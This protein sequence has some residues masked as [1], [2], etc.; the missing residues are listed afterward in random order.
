MRKIIAVLSLVIFA[1]PSMAGALTIDPDFGN[2]LD[3]GTADLSST[4]INVIQWAL[5]LLGLVAVAVIIFGI[6]VV[7]TAGG[8]DRADRA[9][10]LI[11]GAVI[12]LFIII[13]AWSI[14]T[15]VVNTGNE[16]TN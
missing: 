11:I 14:V 4:V 1:L 15:F 13:I 9:K 10:R 12:G 5:G 3:L 16:L 6:V 2:T 8:T 7:A